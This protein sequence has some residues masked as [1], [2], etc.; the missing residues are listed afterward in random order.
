MP[1]PGLYEANARDIASAMSL[2]RRVL[3][4]MEDHHSRF[5]Q[6]LRE[7]KAKIVAEREAV[8]DF[9]ETYPKETPCS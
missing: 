6:E 1:D 3:S 8:E 9:E 5:M 7:S 2:L 4:S